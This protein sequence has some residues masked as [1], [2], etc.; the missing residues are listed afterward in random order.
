M[1]LPPP[2]PKSSNGLSTVLYKCN[3][4]S[5]GGWCHSVNYLKFRNQH[6][7]EKNFVMWTGERWGKEEGL[8]GGIHLIR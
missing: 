4:R 1:L 3:L 6:K 8:G 7:I 2:R 5:S